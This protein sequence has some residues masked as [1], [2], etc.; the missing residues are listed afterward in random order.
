M[1]SSAS[2]FRTVGKSVLYAFGIGIAAIFISK[3]II[4]D[5]RDKH[6]ITAARVMKDN[7]DDKNRDYYDNVALVR[8]G[9][10]LPRE[11]QTLKR[12]NRYEGTGV[13]AATRKRGDKLGF[14]DRRNN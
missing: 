2:P 7:E 5:R 1:N 4:R 9:F 11:E 13:S 3:S 6:F 8:P 12:K 10:P 14:W